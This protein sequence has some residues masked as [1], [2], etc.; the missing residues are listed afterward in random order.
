M[1]ISN[2]FRLTYW[3]DSSVLD[4][5]AGS[6]MWLV[7][8]A[9]L[10]WCAAGIAM[11]IR[12]GRVTLPRDVTAA[13]IAAGLL[14]AAVGVGRLY[15]IPLL[16]LRI[17]WLIASIIAVAPLT[18]RLVR[19]ALRDGIIGDCLAAMTLTRPPAAGYLGQGAI[20]RADGGGVPSWRLS[21]ALS[22]LFFNLAGSAIVMAV[23]RLP[24]WYGPAVVGVISVPYL[25]SI[26]WQWITGR[27][28]RRNLL[29]QL[30]LTALSSLL[31]IYFILGLRVAVAV[32][33]QAVT[34]TYSVVDPFDSL[35]NLL[36]WLAIMTAYGLV[37][38]IYQALR[39]VQ[40]QTTAGT[41][42]R[43]FVKLASLAL[44]AGIV[45]WAVWNALTL[46]TWGVT[47]SDPYAYAQMGVD[48][49]QH[50][51]VFHSFPLIRLTYALNIPSEPII[52][53]GYKLPQDVQRIATTV[54]P[55]GYAVFTALGYLAAGEQGLY[56]I[57]PLLSLLSLAAIWG[58]SRALLSVKT[59]AQPSEDGF[60]FA[61]AAL[62]VAFT[63]TSYQQ[64]EWQMIP[65]ADIAAQLFSLLAVLL[66]F[67]APG[68]SM[69][70]PAL[71]IALAALSGVALGIAFDV[72]YTQVLVA[73]A[74]LFALIAGNRREQS[75]GRGWLARQ[76]QA[77]LALGLGAL[78]A[79]APVL[80]YHTV[81]FGSPFHTGSEE[82]SNFSLPRLPETLARIT[83]ELASPREFGLLLPF[84]IIGLIALWRRDRRALLTLLLYFAPLFLLHIAYAYLRPRDIL[85]LFP[86]LSFL[87]ALGIV[88]LVMA[89]TDNPGRPAPRK[90][91]RPL[92]GILTFDAAR[93]DIHP[94]HFA[95]DVLRMALVV[96]LS[97][98]LMLR[99]LQTLQLPITRGF[100]A[101]GYLVREQRASFTRLGELTP[102]NAVIGCSLNS[103]AVDLYAGRLT[104]R[105]GRWTP[106]QADRFVRA[107]LQEKTPVYI[108][109]D[110]DEVS[111]AVDG[112]RHAF[113]LVEVARLDVPY[114][115]P[116]SGSENR[117]AALYQVE[118]GD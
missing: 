50:G 58:L 21:T 118:I 92:H 26:A 107:L 33:A 68:E 113:R 66:A 80:V 108:L 61:V 13:Q 2:L 62:T 46:H 34:G 24:L 25:I 86:L 54:W 59:G 116:G 75:D 27:L 109:A 78:A 70:R 47:G 37:I 76:M 77:L 79:A 10:V 5:P 104:F 51:T 117:K 106:R 17:G 85:S 95:L 101:F 32:V 23:L 11:S 3:L 114:Y 89:L 103:G 56:L 12:R 40:S 35:L 57:T 42:D 29:A 115:F 73:P 97:F 45:A 8:A 1:R 96:G 65:M 88:R 74:L 72:R 112:L 69:Q 53:V 31:V 49:A 36:L 43:R 90:P 63:A 60:M 83:S 44:V 94:T 39:A 16:G 48:L 22:W 82:L 93:L 99:S 91:L 52:H 4:H 84:I 6:L 28:D 87:A 67:G 30:R 81:A 15:Q 102:P 71:R 14:V 19:Q 64:V 9:G 38:A 55:P 18:P 20:S 98:L 111:A 105:P 100:D 41:F 7:V 110:G